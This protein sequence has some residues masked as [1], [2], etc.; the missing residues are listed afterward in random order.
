MP[1]GS[2]E[3]N[4]VQTRMEQ[5]RE[6]I[7]Q[8]EVGVAGLHADNVLDMLRLRSQAETTVAEEEALGRDLRGERTRLATID[9]MLE[10]H[11]TR[12]VTLAARRGGLRAAREQEAPPSGYWWW[13]LD[14]T[15]ADRLRH[16]VVR[17][18]AVIIGVVL[19]LLLGNYLL[20][21]F[22]GMSPEEREA[23]GFTTMAEQM[24]YVG[25]Y[26]E[27]IDRYEQAVEVIPDLPEAWVALAALY[28]VQGREDDHRAALARAETLV[29]DPLRLRLLLARQYETVQLLDVALAYAEQALELDPGSAEAHL[30][31]GGIHDSLGNRELA[32]ADF[33]Y[34]SELARERGEDALYVLARTRMGMLLQQG[35]L[36]LPG[37]TG[38]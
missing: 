34:A 4:R 14:D 33:E 6:Q 25:E 10:R 19:V 11:A 26:E 22:F 21:T 30:I 32:L 27:A 24:I 23:Y 12:V 5:L 2:L 31:R 16:S 15:V 17:A 18:G 38:P 35:D 9:N 37:G 7:R 1:K 13:Y 29:G 20:N 3:N 28:D 8:L 36:A